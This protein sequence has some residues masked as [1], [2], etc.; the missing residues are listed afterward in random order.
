MGFSL[1]LSGLVFYIKWADGP[2]CINRNCMYNNIIV[3]LEYDITHIYIYNLYKIKLIQQSGM[4]LGWVTS[5]CTQPSGGQ[6]LNKWP[7]VTWASALT[8]WPLDQV[9]SKISFALWFKTWSNAVKTSKMCQISIF[10]DGTWPSGTWRHSAK[11]YPGLIRVW[12]QWFPPR[13]TKW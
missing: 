8:N 12:C 9:P 3:Y 5:P 2:S 13:C 11:W 4:L 7:L 1:R 10:L 6:H